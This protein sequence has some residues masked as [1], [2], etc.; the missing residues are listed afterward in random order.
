MRLLLALSAATLLAAPLAA[1]TR[2]DDAREEAAIRET[3]GHYLQGHATGDSAH[4]RLAFHKAAMLFSVRDGKLLTRT[5]DEYIAGAAGRPAA[6]EAKR[7]RKIVSIHRSGDAAMA[8]VELAY[9][10]VRFVDYM[11]LLKVGGE[12][13]IVNKTFQAFPKPRPAA[14]SAASATSTT[15][16]I[17]TT[18]PAEKPAK[19]KG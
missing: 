7:K 11:S 1:Q 16:G 5:S 13:K 15:P 14:A 19:K 6:D 8:V 10:E 12:W 3:L 18:P 4:F 9:P 2:A 17:S